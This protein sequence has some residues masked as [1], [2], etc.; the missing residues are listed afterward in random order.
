M[1]RPVTQRLS[2]QP[3]CAKPWSLH[4]PELH[5]THWELQRTTL[6]RTAS[7]SHGPG[8]QRLKQQATGPTSSV[9]VL[10]EA[11][12]ELHALLSALSGREGHL[13]P[14]HEQVLRP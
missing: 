7:L 4:G 3:S 11:Q 9:F 12:Y 8:R 5:C 14:A 6:P 13:A 2:Q 1:S 10:L